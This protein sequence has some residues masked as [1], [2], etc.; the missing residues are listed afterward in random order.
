MIKSLCTEL[1][2]IV[3]IIVLLLL[4]QLSM[5]P[6]A[7]ADDSNTNL[8]QAKSLVGLAASVSFAGVITA[9]TYSQSNI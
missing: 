6:I 7:F 5:A 9:G 2:I 4:M 3:L 1:V 8:S